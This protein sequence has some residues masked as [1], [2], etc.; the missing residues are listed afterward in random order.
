M[1]RFATGVILCIPKYFKVKKKIR[2]IDQLYLGPLNRSSRLIK[3]KF[4]TGKLSFWSSRQRTLVH[5]KA[6]AFF[7]SEKI[8]LAKIC[9]CSIVPILQ[10]FFKMCSNTQQLWWNRKKSKITKPSQQG[11]VLCQLKLCKVHPWP[12]RSLRSKQSK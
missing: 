12:E 2:R 11:T 8:N 1:E 7:K 10:F 9:H 3:R 5:H 4:S 6:K